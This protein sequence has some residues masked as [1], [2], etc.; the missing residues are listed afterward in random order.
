MWALSIVI[1]RPIDR[2]GSGYTDGK[3]TLGPYIR[4]Y[5][6]KMVKASHSK[7]CLFTNKSCC[8]FDLSTIQDALRTKRVRLQDDKWEPQLKESRSM[9]I[10]NNKFLNGYK[11]HIVRKKMLI[12]IICI[13]CEKLCTRNIFEEINHKSMKSKWRRL[14]DVTFSLMALLFCSF[15]F[16]RGKHCQL[17]RA[18][19]YKARC[20]SQFILQS[21]ARNKDIKQLTNSYYIKNKF[22][23]Y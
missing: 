21:L 23:L 18:G 15:V 19:A 6:V 14:S 12:H 11:Q 22:I 13:V 16:I 2:H 9:K 3:D 4:Q 5:K 20:V 1:F 7:C 10:K 17:G 8:T